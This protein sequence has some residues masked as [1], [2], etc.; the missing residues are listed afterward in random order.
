M[1][2]SIILGTWLSLCAVD[3]VD[4]SKLV[5]VFEQLPKATAA[6]NPYAA[7]RSPGSRM[8]LA[9]NAT[10]TTDLAALNAEG[11]DLFLSRTDPLTTPEVAENRW[12]WTRAVAERDAAG[13]TD[14][15]WGLML[16]TAFPPAWQRPRFKADF[17]TSLDGVTVVPGLSPWSAASG[18]FADRI[19][20]ASARQFGTVPV[21]VVG[22]HGAY[23]DAGLPGDVADLSDEMQ[24]Q[25]LNT[26]GVKLTG[27]EFWCGDLAAKENFRQAVFQ[28]YGSLEKL[29]AAWGV[30][31]KSEEDIPFPIGPDFSQRARLD[32][33]NWY[34]IGVTNMAV[35][36]IEAAK[37]AYPNAL[38]LLPVGPPDDNLKYGTDIS[39]LIEMAGKH[40]ANVLITNG[41]YDTFAKDHALGFGLA[42]AASRWYKTPLWL[43][44]AAPGDREGFN[45]RLAEALSLGAIGY[46][47]WSENWRDY[48][49][50]VDRL[51]RYL[52]VGTPQTDVA[53]IYPTTTQLLKNEAPAP[54]VYMQLATQLRDY[55]DF[56]VLDERLI[57]AGALSNYRIAI[58]C[59]GV[60]WEQATLNEI[61]AW[62]KAGGVL[63][64]YDF[65]KMASSEGRSDSFARLFPQA[66][67]TGPGSLP[68]RF[69]GKIPDAYEIDPSDGTS[70]W[71]LEGDWLEPE[72]ADSGVPLRYAGKTASIHLALRP[73]QDYSLTLRAHVPEHAQGFDRK[74]LFDGRL[75]GKLTR[76]GDSIYRFVIPASW[77]T[78]SAARLTL[79]SETWKYSEVVDGS[80][81]DRVIGIGIRHLIV[82]R[83]DSSAKPVP[84]VGAFVAAADAK[85][86]RDQ[87]IAK[88]GNGMTVF[89][90]NTKT[91]LSDYLAIARVLIYRL[92]ELDPARANAP[93]VDDRRDGVY[94]SLA[95]DK[96]VFYNSTA[97]QMKM[98][99]A[100]PG[101]T[102]ARSIT[103]EPGLVTVV[104]TT[105]T[106]LDL[107]LQCEKF[108]DLGSSQPINRADCSPGAGTTG[109]MVDDGQSIATRF[110]I[111]QP[112]SYV[113][114]V[115]ALR[116]QDLILPKITLDDAAVSNGKLSGPA[117]DVYRVGE[118]A[119]SVGVHKLSIS[120]ATAFTA[121]FIVL[122]NTPN[123]KGFRFGTK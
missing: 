13:R 89:F 118:L 109:Q 32:F 26:I 92:S 110:E 121:D 120:D 97:S 69:E 9:S 4:P 90:P 24:A 112:G 16:H 5:R 107:L 15:S 117:G 80:T 38:L 34:R 10:V 21:V 84:L 88:V 74:L 71:L 72:P 54:S 77:I 58:L 70:E 59:E 55:A 93:R 14:A 105:D 49:V 66:G 30:E 75:V 98:D 33:A 45:E 12:N 83:A 17:L 22:V 111:E 113:L 114:Y 76:S 52:T 123:V 61:E 37:S 28:K 27:P 85:L 91:R 44:S 68:E 29:N 41:G 67:K 104:P 2:V 56:D 3:S 6:Q 43:Q 46:S 96:A 47:E 19:W 11:V 36:N 119:L 95:G 48:S 25:W 50:D 103:V 106:A 86:V 79:E 31:T 40:G 51:T 81:D 35:R 60:A 64:A 115:R 42:R 53:L 122:S 100:L 20:S 23:G 62:V 116:G 87:W 99:V 94:T 78:R 18:T 63:S 7:H 8:A 65:G 57:Q 1:C 73:G 39:G 102:V 82:R 101:Q 108:V